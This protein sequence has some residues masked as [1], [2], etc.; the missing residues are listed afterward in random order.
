MIQPETKLYFRVSE[1]QLDSEYFA[2]VN[3]EEKINNYKSVTIVPIKDMKETKELI[4]GSRNVKDCIHSL[5]GVP[6]YP[7]FPK[8]LLDLI[9]QRGMSMSS[10]VGL[11]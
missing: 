10:R 9:L 1:G 7:V 4:C 2:E 8:L 6:L 5:N 11:S 3:K